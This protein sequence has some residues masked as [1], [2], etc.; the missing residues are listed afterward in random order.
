MVNASPP[1]TRSTIA[2]SASVKGDGEMSSVATAPRETSSICLSGSAIPRS[3]NA[4]VPSA[5]S[6][7]V[8]ETYPGANHLDT[9]KTPVGVRRESTTRQ[10]SVV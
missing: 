6:L 10:A 7:L 3:I 2:R 1:A 9:L 8:S 5:S 4:A